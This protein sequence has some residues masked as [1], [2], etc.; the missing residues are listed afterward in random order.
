MPLLT[1]FFIAIALAVDA[2]AVSMAT[3]ACL[4]VLSLGHVVRLAVSFGLFQAGMNIIGW[5]GGLFFR[6]SFELYDHWIAFTILVLV[7]LNMIR[8]SRK[9]HD[10]DRC[11]PD[12]T[13]GWTLFVLSVATSIDALAVG[14]SF[15]MLKVN[16]WLPATLIGL[17]AFA[18]TVAGINLGRLL[19]N[20]PII[21]SR[22]EV[23]GGVVL[24][25][26][27]VRILH[28]HGVF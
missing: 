22:A 8:E 12:P 13:R 14:I 6:A 9:K 25:T 26:I 16:I 27:G 18:L 15:S 5:A 7:G 17:V 2:F 24:L 11:P 23:A 4:P 20:A 10:C 19:R 28:E 3:G 1:Q 21:G